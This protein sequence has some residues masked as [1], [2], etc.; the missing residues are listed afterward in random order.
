MVLPVRSRVTVAMLLAG[1]CGFAPAGGPGQ[2]DDD[3]GPDDP[4]AAVEPDAR[5]VDAPAIDAPAPIDLP[6][7]EVVN[8]QP[9]A[10]DWVITD[11]VDFDS[12]LDPSSPGIPGLPA[13]VTFTLQ[14]Q[15]VT[16]ARSILVLHVRRLELAAT[17]NLYMYGSRPVAI[18]AGGDVD[19]A[20]RID[21]S[22]WTSDSTG[23]RNPGPGGFSGTDVAGAGGGGAIPATGASDTGGGG[24]GHGTPGGRGGGAGC[25]ADVCAV[26]P[27]AGGTAINESRFYLGGGGRGGAAVT[28]GPCIARTGGA[29]GGGLYIYSPTSITVTASGTIEANGGGGGGGRYCGSNGTLAGS[30]GGAGGQ[31]ELQAPVIVVDSG[32]LVVANGGAGGGGANNTGSNVEGTAGDDGADSLTEA[33]PGGGGGGTGGDG[34]AGSVGAGAGGNGEHVDLGANGGGGGGGGGRIVLRYRGTQPAIV[35]SPPAAFVAY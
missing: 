25:T 2:G 32:G 27:G 35:T 24:G 22:A 21:A 28:R 26:A 30:G 16:N 7:L 12:D 10:G 17:G 19:I 14:A 20:G 9:G 5:V 15:N 31:I 11:D 6:Y 23:A 33:T 1:G 34:G 4:D 13:G 18:V 8:E 3:G 29:G